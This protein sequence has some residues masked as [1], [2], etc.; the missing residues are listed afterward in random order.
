MWPWKK[1]KPQSSWVCRVCGLSH[2]GAPSD[3]GWELPDEVWAM[4]PE[5]RQKMLEWSTEMSYH[6]GRWFLRGVLELPHTYDTGCWGWGVWAEVDESVMK[7]YS[8]LAQVDGSNEP[9]MFGKLA[10]KIPLY[11]DSIN[12]PLEIQFTTPDLRPE[13]YLPADSLHLLA[14]EQRNG[15]DEERYHEIVAAILG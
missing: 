4:G 8:E 11:P 6:D 3:F 13:F 15:M 12:L 7:K 14:K 10:C 2:E 5:H 9:R 1:E